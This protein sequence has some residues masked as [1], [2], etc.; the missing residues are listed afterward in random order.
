[1]KVKSVVKYNLSSLK[2]SILMFYFVFISICVLLTIL[3]YNSDGAVSSSGIELSSAIF[4]FVVGL[5]MFKENFY[6]IK[7][8]NLSRKSYFYGTVLSMVPISIGMSFIDIILNRIYNIFV[9]CPTNYDMIYT[10]Y[11]NISNYANNGWIQSNSIETLF[12]TFLF[13]ASV[14][15]MAFILGF[16]ITMLYYKCNKLMK[17]VISIIPILLIIIFNMGFYIMALNFPYLTGKIGEW[18]FYILGIL[19]RN[20]YMTISTF[21]IISVVLATVAYLL[22]RKMRIKEK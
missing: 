1:M 3:S 4:I 14:Y 15:L 2:N 17:T 9:N 6:F 13:Q 22:I 5:N 19:P 7:G 18:V 16:V 12:N 10:D 8:N 11:I 21:S 20:V